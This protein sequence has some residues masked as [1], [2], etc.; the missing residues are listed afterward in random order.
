MSADTP[1][2]L[3]TMDP[4]V[5]LRTIGIKKLRL[6]FHPRKGLNDDI[7]AQYVE[8]L[9]EGTPVEPVRVYFD[10]D[11]YYLANAF[12]GWQQRR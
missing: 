4:R 9:V 6:D 5:R 11:A 2:L 1:H 3:G 7:V 12:I 8:K 10:G